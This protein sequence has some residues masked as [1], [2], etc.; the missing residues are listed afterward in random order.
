MANVYN[1]MYMNEE[2]ITQMHTSWSD[3]LQEI[4]LE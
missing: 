4:I 1:Y 2:I 3:L